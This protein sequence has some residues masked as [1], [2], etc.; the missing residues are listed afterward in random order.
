MSLKQYI[1]LKKQDVLIKMAVIYKFKINKM[2][3]KNAS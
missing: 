2:V 3:I 1:P